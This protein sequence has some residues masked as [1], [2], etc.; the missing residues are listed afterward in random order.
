MRKLLGS[1]SG[2][3]AAE[4][5]A[6]SLQD[7]LESQRAIFQRA[8]APGLAHRLAA[9]EKLVLLLSPF[10]PHMAE[11]LWQ[12]LG[13]DKS[14]AYEPWPEFDPAAVKQDTIEVPV[15]INGK[16]RADVTVARDAKPA[17]IEAAVLALD[18]VIRALD[19]KSPKKVIVVPQRIV[20]VVA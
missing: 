14:L 12:L 6:P 1:V 3:V 19:G 7:I 17:E 11:E 5:P 2:K 10:A 9:L 4:A 20:N 8:G 15:Q 13:H 16:K 18:A